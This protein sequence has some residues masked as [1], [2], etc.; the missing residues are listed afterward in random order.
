MRAH[1]AA[2]FALTIG[3]VCLGARA[4]ATPQ[5][6]FGLGARTFSMGGTGTAFCNDYSCVHANPAGLSRVDQTSLTLGY[7]GASFGLRTTRFGGVDTHF[8]EDILRATIVGIATQLPVGLRDPYRLVLGIG[9][10]LPINLIGRDRVLDANAPQFVIL[11]DRAQVVGLQAGAGLS[12]PGGFRIGA[13]GSA[14]AALSGSLFVTADSAGRVS[15]R[16]DDRLV[17]SYSASVGASWERGPI[18]VGIVGRTPLVGHLDV[19]ITARDL[20]INLPPFNIAGTPQYDPW[21]LGAE[22]SF[23]HTGWTVALGAIMKFWGFYP[24]PL[25]ATTTQSDRP[26][27]PQFSHTVVPRVGVEHHWR[28]A[29]SHAAVRAGYAY[30]PTPAPL[31]TAARAYMDNDRHIVTAGLGVGGRLRGTLMQ[32]DVFAQLHALAPR[33]APA[34]PGTPAA[35]PAVREYSFGGTVLM[36]G[37]TLTVSL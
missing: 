23:A 18:R 35:I 2:G 24:G 31:P 27:P 20:G 7:A 5:D 17:V 36:L 4:D 29:T 13:G 21:E 10:F 3:I 15:W 25:E 37:A 33:T 26:P 9:L 6:L 30:E 19:R 34:D 16:I 32:V 28:W 8:G 22:A 14:L 11:P 12:L 1:V